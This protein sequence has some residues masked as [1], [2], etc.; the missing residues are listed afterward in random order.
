MSARGARR[1][2]YSALDALGQVGW[3]IN[4]PMHAAVEA[5]WAAGGGVC[6]LPSAADLPAVPPPGAMRFR[7]VSTRRGQLLV[8][9][10]STSVTTLAGADNREAERVPCAPGAAQRPA[11]GAANAA[12][13][14]RVLQTMC[15]ALGRGLQRWHPP[16]GFA[17]LVLLI[18]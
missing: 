15:T 7:T 4:A 6:E 2:V 11:S 14:A 13:P 16:G 9:V 10:R 18:V 3:R 12:M 8:T 17:M 5:A 1:Q